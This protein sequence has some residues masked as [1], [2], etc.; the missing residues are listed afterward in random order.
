MNSEQQ[1]RI[2]VGI[3]ACLLGEQVR[4]DGGH[5]HDRYLTGTLGCYFEWVPVCPEVEVGLGTPRPAMR[6][7][8]H[9]GLVR[10][11]VPKTG[12]DL[13]G[14]MNDWAADRIRALASEDLSGYIL[15]SKSP[16]CGMERV[17]VYKG[18]PSGEPDG[19]EGT[20]D[21][22]GPAAQR[23]PEPAPRT[24]GRGLFA[25]RL[26]EAFPNL[27]VEEEGRL[28]DPRLRE[29]W[30]ER[31]FAYHDLKRL[32]RPG[33][34][35][36][37]LVEFHTRYKFVLLAHSQQAYAALGRLAAEA[38]SWDRDALRE[39]YEADFMGALRHIA[40]PQ[41]NV[42]VLQ[43]IVGFFKDDLD[44]VSREELLNH[45]EDYRRGYVPLAVP[46]TLVSHYV[47]LLDVGY[48][49]DQV[50]LNPHPK[51]LALRSHV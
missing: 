19:D 34:T 31:V 40:T 22:G 18:R 15:K 3:S 45:I 20:T 39:R 26:M 48:L 49:R 21:A 51:E 30:V 8:D 38:G 33:W 43:H 23:R 1:Q 25:A 36:G 14:E 32:W 13:T 6:L 35:T 11:V 37:D 5:K 10:L 29:N 42:N 17:R 47:R 12:R 27:P 46:L 50:F 7:E 16:S 28:C 2:R 4:H 44:R 41:R 24:N 9:D